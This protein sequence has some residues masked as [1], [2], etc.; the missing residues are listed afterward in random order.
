MYCILVMLSVFLLLLRFVRAPTVPR[1]SAL[2][3]VEVHLLAY[4]Y[5]RTPARY[6]KLE[7]PVKGAADE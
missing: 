6:I 4:V 5:S 3:C 7:N 1:V 2:T